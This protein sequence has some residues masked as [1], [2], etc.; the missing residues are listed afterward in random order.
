MIDYPKIINLKRID[1]IRGNLTFIEGEN[2]IPFKIERV[3]LT[4]DVPG[5]QVRGGHAYK[6]QEEIIV[7]LSGS[8]DVVTRQK[9]QV[10]LKFTLNRSYKALYIPPKTW[11]HIEN[12]STNAVSLHLSSKLYDEDDYIKDFN[13]SESF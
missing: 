5:G 7:A 12:H 8:F 6:T 1:D 2:Q 11:R 13:K 4:Y 10:V 3:F 9:G